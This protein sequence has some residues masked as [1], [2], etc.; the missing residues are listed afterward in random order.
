MLIQELIIEGVSNKIKIDLEKYK[1]RHR[2]SN[3]SVEINEPKYFNIHLII[4]EKEEYLEVDL[5]IDIKNQFLRIMELD[6]VKFVK[7][8]ALEF[9]V[10]NLILNFDDYYSTN[11]VHSDLKSDMLVIINSVLTFNIASISDITINGLGSYLDYFEL[12]YIDL[13]HLKSLNIKDKAPSIKVS[14]NIIFNK[15]WTQ[16]GFFVNNTHDLQQI[17]YFVKKNDIDKINIVVDLDEEG[18]STVVSVDR[19]CF[20]IE[21]YGPISQLLKV[22]YLKNVQNLSI[23]YIDR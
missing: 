1:N 9:E 16:F 15:N 6:I 8:L 17:L 22:L 21:T 7:V 14:D 19:K 13:S 18:F 20:H 5:K 4:H 23:S 11:K 12:K 3:L 2:Y 10:T